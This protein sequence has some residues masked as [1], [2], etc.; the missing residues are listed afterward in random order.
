MTPKPVLCKCYSIPQSFIP[1]RVLLY[2]VNSKFFNRI[3]I[4][5]ILYSGTLNYL[6][7]GTFISVVTCFFQDL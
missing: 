6:S 4:R 5:S 2:T 3:L 7:K 1:R